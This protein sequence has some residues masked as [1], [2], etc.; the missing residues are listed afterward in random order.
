VLGRPSGCGGA[1]KP[2]FSDASG[3]IRQNKITFRSLHACK[4]C[5]LHRLS[6][7]ARSARNRRCRLCRGAR[8]AL[9]Q[10]LLHSTLVA[11]SL[12]AL[13]PYD[14]PMKRTAGG[15]EALSLTHTHPGLARYMGART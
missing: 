1:C 12:P 2:I 14:R 15:G 8:A 7:W 13:H 10:H 11:P 3:A 5:A 4:H 9:S 6:S